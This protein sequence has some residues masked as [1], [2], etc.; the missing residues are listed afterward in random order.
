MF[1]KRKNAVTAL[2]VLFICIAVYLNWNYAGNIDDGLQ[3][4][5]DTGKTLGEVTLA[6]NEAE[7]NMGKEENVV[8]KNEKNK[9]ASSQGE[10]GEYFANAR[11]EKQKARDNALTILKDTV[12]KTQVSQQERDKAAAKMENLAAGAISETRIETL[13]K[14][15]GFEECV[16][17]INEEVVNVIVKAPEKGLTQSDTTKIKD[18]VISETKV[19]PGQI[20]IVEIK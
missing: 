3:D 2:V 14:A 16:T 8:E 17:L 6:N 12:E 18:I 10:A 19:D 9:D 15:K 11:L 4:T 7:D 13:I 1:M 5:M 20:K